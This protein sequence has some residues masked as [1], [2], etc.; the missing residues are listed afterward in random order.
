[1]RQEGAAAEAAACD[2]AVFVD[3]L[4]DGPSTHVAFAAAFVGQQPCLA[5][6]AVH[7]LAALIEH[8]NIN[9]DLL[10]AAG[11]RGTSPLS[12]A[13]SSP[14]PAKVAAAPGCQDVGERGGRVGA[15]RVR[16]VW[17]SCFR[18]RSLV[19]YKVVVLASKRSGAHSPTLPFL[20]GW[21]EGGRQGLSMW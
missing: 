12:P 1:M 5:A 16:C 15:G 11:T 9:P 3:S 7:L 2:M 14:G 10:D 6:A 21:G 4:V 20:P 18:A 17:E 19:R 13:L 8:R